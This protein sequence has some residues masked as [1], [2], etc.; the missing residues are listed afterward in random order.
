[1]VPSKLVI[2]TVPDDEQAITPPAPREVQSSIQSSYSL[3][4]SARHSSKSWRSLLWSYCVRHSFNPETYS[5][6]QSSLQVAPATALGPARQVMI[7]IITAQ[8][9]KHESNEVAG[10]DEDE[11]AGCPRLPGAGSSIILSNLLISSASAWAG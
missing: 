7:S 11:A 2:S 1:V 3:R 9:R 8:S 6:L 10:A 4:E 5:F